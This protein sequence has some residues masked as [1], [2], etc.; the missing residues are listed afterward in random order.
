LY[1]TEID[2]TFICKKYSPIYPEMR[3][4]L[5]R[6]FVQEIK[7]LHQL[8]HR[9][10]VR[11]FNYYIYSNLITG[12]I[13]M[14]YVDGSEID[15]YATHRPQDLDDLFL[16]AI[17]GFSYLEERGVLHR[18][19]RASNLMVTADGTLKIID[20]GFGKKVAVSADFDKSI[21]LNWPVD[22]PREF[23][24]GRYDFATEVYFVGKLFADIIAGFESSSFNH[25]EIVRKMC[26]LD[27]E[28]R[29]SSFAEIRKQV[30]GEQLAAD[31]TEDDIEVYRRFSSSLLDIVQKIESSAAYVTDVSAVIASLDAT[32]RRSML[33]I[34]I[35]SH[36]DIVRAFVKG[37]YYYKTSAWFEVGVLKEF[38]Q[39]LKK[40]SLENK[41]VIADNIRGRLDAVVRYTDADGDIPF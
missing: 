2:Q 10:V 30:S 20:F 13:L 39:L 28:S 26:R 16:Q 15:K 34:Y 24:E 21:T 3:E 14:E 25:I 33:E 5:F 31:F 36:K 29:F 7:I 4:E 18:D 17:D 1:D 6:N 32:Y 41:N 35:Y 22:P 37:G 9:N 19:I 23:E 12:Y 40:S 11:V 27:P 8:F 38:L